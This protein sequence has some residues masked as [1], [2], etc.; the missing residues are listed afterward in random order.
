MK[1][2]LHL[3]PI[4]YGAARMLASEF[5]KARRQIPLGITVCVFVACVTGLLVW[6]M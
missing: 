2:A 5:Q 1:T 6:G 4:R 3:T